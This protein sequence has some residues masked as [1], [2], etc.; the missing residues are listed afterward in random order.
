MQTRIASDRNPQRA[1]WTKGRW[2]LAAMAAPS[3]VL[4]LL[5]AYLPLVGWL[6][7]FFDYKPG[8]D[9]LKLHFAGL[10][11]VVLAFSDG[12]ILKILRN[13]LVMSGLNL[14]FSPLP[15]VFAIF[16]S[17]I[18]FKWIR[19][20]IQT[21]TT[22]PNFISWVLVFALAYVMFN[23]ND[24]LVNKLIVSIGL[25]DKSLDILGNE[26]IVWYFQTAIGIWKGLGFSAIVYVAAITGIDPEQV[27][28]AA[29]D[30]AGRFRRIWH[31]VMP[32]LLP[33]YF[34]LLLL[35]IGN[36][37]NN[38]FEQYYLF[39][40]GLVANRIEVLDYYVYRMGIFL[41]NYP[42]STAIGMTKTL[43][44]VLLLTIANRLSRTLLDRKLF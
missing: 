31:V 11:Y 33:T 30:G 15:M 17:E 9:F 6:L 25:S 39:Y 44:S 40:N 2:T 7:A 34:V 24:G 32:G 38:G 43:V 26:D 41:G 14:L 20:T 37:L 42:I 27:D 29:V 8:Y 1:R 18:R 3:L 19:K 36:L 23:I 22:L 21:T 13:T 10:K 28:A 5:F 12:E 35:G 4:L 16:L